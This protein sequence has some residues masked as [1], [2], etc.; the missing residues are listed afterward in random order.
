MSD[1]VV[2]NQAK[3]GENWRVAVS[4]LQN[5]FLTMHRTLSAAIPVGPTELLIYATVSTANVQRL[6]RERAIP[7]PFAGTAILPR[8]WVVPISRNA[9]A[10]ASGLP[11]ETVRRH[12]ARMIEAGLLIEDSRGGVTL[13]EGVIQ[14]RQLEPFL[15]GMLTIYARSA[16]ELLRSGVIRIEK[17]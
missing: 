3:I 11:R 4:S 2:T 15:E 17:D 6:M 5:L 14:D 7:E 12:V 13:P 10:T 1:R 9:I 16:E 8:E